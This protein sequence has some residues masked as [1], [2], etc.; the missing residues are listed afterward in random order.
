MKYLYITLLLSLL[1]L[2]NS[3]SQEDGQ[4]ISIGKYHII[5]SHILDEERKILVHLP[6]GYETTDLD[7]PVIYHLYGDFVMTYFADAAVTIERIFDAGMMPQAILIG[8]DN[9]D[10]Y[11]HLRPIA[12]DGS[13]GGMEKFFNYLKEELM[14][15]INSN[16]RTAGFD[17][18]VGP[19]AGACFGLC[20]LIKHTDLFD[21][22][23]LE[24]SFDNPSNID[25][26]LLGEMEEFFS[27]GKT[28][29][30]YLFMTLHKGSRNM[31]VALKE[32]AIIE[33]NTPTNFDF[34]FKLDEPS[35]FRPYK[36]NLDEAIRTLYNGYKMP[37]DYPVEN[38]GD[39]L[40]YYD[41]LSESIGYKVNITDRILY[42]AGDK[43]SQKGN[44]AEA[45]K[46][47]E[48]ILESYPSSLDGLFRLARMETSAG[49][50]EKAKTYYER[51]LSIRPSETFIRTQLNAVNDSIMKKRQ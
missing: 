30:K 21:A 3:F 27:P 33:A 9:T 2:I 10:R 38:F 4:E 14:T 28:L 24:N 31:E 32:K 20:A 7:Y 13:T 37:E 36:T 12:R 49:N 41:D 43:I 39:I 22:I 11:T 19:Q 40:R 51:F 29:D 16:F 45:K 35:Y 46:T 5:N 26:Y 17:I 25:D 1:C 15:Y 47:Y 6:I 23:I 8:V 18:L 44:Q 42:L 50:F 48:F 34:Y